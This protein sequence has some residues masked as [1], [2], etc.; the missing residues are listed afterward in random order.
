M[1]QYPPTC[2]GLG[3]V[4]TLSFAPSQITG[5]PKV[6]PVKRF[7]ACLLILPLLVSVSF[8]EEPEAAGLKFFETKIRPAL[9]EHCVDCHGVDEQESE[10]RLD[11]P[12]HLMAGGK[13][14]PVAI[15]GEPDRSL[16]VSAIRYKDENLQMPPDEKLPISVVADLVKWIEMGAR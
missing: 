10:L 8:A 2:R 5:L 3:E 1:D 14:G 15:P 16:L 9:I 4:E 7:P 11:T 12:A 13:S 6:S